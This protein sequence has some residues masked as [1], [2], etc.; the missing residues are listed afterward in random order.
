MLASASF[1][2]IKKPELQES[3]SHGL[4]G[5]GLF[6]LNPCTAGTLWY[7]IFLRDCYLFKC[8]HS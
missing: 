6:L 2:L 7:L 3:T 1:H 4:Q 8:S 5:Y